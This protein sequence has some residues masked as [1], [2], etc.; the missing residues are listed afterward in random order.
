MSSTI[1]GM[2]RAA[3]SARAGTDSRPRIGPTISPT[4]RSIAVHS[5]PPTTWQKVS[6]HSQ[7]PA[8]A[9]MTNATTTATVGSPRTGTTC[10]CGRGGLCATTSACIRPTSVIQAPPHR[11]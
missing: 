3:N 2:N 6:A 9:A 1:F 11:S 10:T 8:I 5:P 4:N 7:L